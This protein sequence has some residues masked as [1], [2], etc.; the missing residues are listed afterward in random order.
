V[1]LM[2]SG[3]VLD[4]GT[5]DELLERSPEYR[6]VVVRTMEEAVDV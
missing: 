4:Q 6:H 5:H 3:R 2:G 1:A